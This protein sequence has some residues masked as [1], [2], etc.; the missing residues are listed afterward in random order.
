MRA[1]IASTVT[2]FAVAS[3]AGSASAEPAF[4]PAGTAAER[5]LARILKLDGDKPEAVDPAIAGSLRRPRAAPPPDAAYLAWLTAPLAAT[6]LTAEA[7]AVKANCGGVYRAGDEC[8]LDAD[9]ILCAQDF[10]KSY[11]FRTTQ[12]A[13]GLAVVE[14][15]WPP[16][17]RA[18][19]AASGAYRLTRTGG[20]WKIDGVK[21]A[22]GGGAYNWR[23]R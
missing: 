2:A 1:A 5:T 6:I 8:G 15:A 20:V 23:E 14:A 4:H 3:A 16:E 13:P 17:G 19:P 10:P 12:S 18:A 22:E 21:C 7:R 11:L 9:P